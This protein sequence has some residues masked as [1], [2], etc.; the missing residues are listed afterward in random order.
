MGLLA[1]NTILLA[2]R[3]RT[4]CLWQRGAQLFVIL[5]FSLPVS[6]HA[7][8][9]SSENNLKSAFIFNFAKYVEWPDSAFN[10]KGTFCIAT[11]GRSPLDKELAS[12]SGKSV[13]GRD[14]VFRQ[15]N[16]PEEATQCQ[17][18]FI[19]RSEVSRV[20]AILDVFKDLPVLTIADLDDFCR[21]GGMLSLVN[22]NGKIVFDVNILETQR[23]RLKPNP[24]LLRLTRKIY[25]RS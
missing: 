22:E 1:V 24:Q 16:S 4:H 18:L 6:G 11:L 7:E 9:T 20:E 10:G 14:I 15:F 13:Q 3:K 19:S 25:G 5:L 21:R 23:V 12:L 8:R 2:L 17:V